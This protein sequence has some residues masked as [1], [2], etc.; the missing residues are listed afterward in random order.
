MLTSAYRAWNRSQPKIMP[1]ES[2][3]PILTTGFCVGRCH[4]SLSISSSVM[5]EPTQPVH[6]QDGRFCCLL[7]YSESVQPNPLRKPAIGYIFSV[8]VVVALD[9]FGFGKIGVPKQFLTPRG[10]ASK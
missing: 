3:I 9:T 1:S 6:D 10:P 4:F 2:S 7:P 5:P 8:V